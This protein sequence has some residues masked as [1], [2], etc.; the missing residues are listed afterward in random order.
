MESVGTMAF[1]KTSE[2]VI[3]ESADRAL[4]AAEDATIL[5]W[6]RVRGIGLRLQ[7]DR[8]DDECAELGRQLVSIAQTNITLAK[9]L[10]AVFRAQADVVD[11]VDPWSFDTALP[12]TAFEVVSDSFLRGALNRMA[13]GEGG[14]SMD[15]GELQQLVE[16]FAS[17][18]E[19]N[20]PGRGARIVAQSTPEPAAPHAS[21]TA[22]DLDISAVLEFDLQFDEPDIPFD[23]SEFKAES[24]ELLAD[25]VDT[26]GELDI[27][28]A[29]DVVGATDAADEA[30]TAAATDGAGTADAAGKGDEAGAI[31]AADAADTVIAD[32]AD[33]AGTADA[34]G[35]ATATDGAAAADAADPTCAID[36]ADAE[37]ATSA[38]DAVAVTTAPAGAIDEAT[39]QF[40]AP[41]TLVYEYRDGSMQLKK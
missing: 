39:P 13:A 40:E 29:I 32:A 18:G 27:T 20:M 33:A 17:G 31:D 28:E 5:S 8:F 34:T 21:A 41:C 19:W 15:S 4:S 22:S 14:V 10:D 38:L 12:D 11:E 30:D 1:E 35:A 24:M 9:R 23:V 37:E 3:A 7:T 16:H 6:E 25:D 36:T 26:T 2:Q